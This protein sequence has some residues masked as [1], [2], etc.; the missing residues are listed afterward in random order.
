MA[1]AASF[2][3][4]WFFMGNPFGFKMQRKCGED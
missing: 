3:D 4:K 1:T 2:R